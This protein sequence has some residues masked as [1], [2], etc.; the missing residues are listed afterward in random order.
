METALS[1]APPD[2]VLRMPAD[3]SQPTPLIAANTSLHPH[4]SSVSACISPLSY[5]LEYSIIAL[6]NDQCSTQHTRPDVGSVE[7]QGYTFLP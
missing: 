3:G 7:P 5:G 4:N 2:Q 1:K 6:S